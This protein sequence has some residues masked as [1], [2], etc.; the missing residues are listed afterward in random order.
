MKLATLAPKS[1]W[2]I[3]RRTARWTLSRPTQRQPPTRKARL[4]D[5]I[6]GYDAGRRQVGRLRWGR[7]KSSTRDQ[8]AGSRRRVLQERAANHSGTAYAGWRVGLSDLKLKLV[9]D[10]S[11]RPLNVMANAK[12]GYHYVAVYDGKGKA[13]LEVVPDQ[14]DLVRDIFTWVGHQRCP[15]SSH[16]RRR[17]S[18]GLPSVC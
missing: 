18:R 13:R 4:G 9:A 2:T 1:R 17:T 11:G 14:A 6:G 5:F 3:R 15:N 12:Y 16:S 8:G 10:E 7:G